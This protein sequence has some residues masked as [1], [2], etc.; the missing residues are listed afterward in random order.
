MRQASTL[1]IGLHGTGDG[2][3]RRSRSSRPESNNAPNEPKSSALAAFD[4]VRYC[5]CSSAKEWNY[6]V[7]GGY[8]LSCTEPPGPPATSTSPRPRQRV[9]SCHLLGVAIAAATTTDATTATNTARM[10]ARRKFQDCWPLP[11]MA[12]RTAEVAIA[13]VIA[14]TLQT[15]VGTRISKAMVR[16]MSRLLPPTM[17]S[18]R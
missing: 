6:V 18:R 3:S 7:V 5:G 11:L 16:R 15:R 1:G 8:A 14:K 13:H 9:A 4:P 12:R 17:T 2:M 10:D